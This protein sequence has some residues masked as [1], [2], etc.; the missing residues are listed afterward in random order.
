MTVT[1]YVL[2]SVKKK[3]FFLSKNPAFYN[4]IEVVP[5]TFIATARVQSWQLQEYKVQ[6]DVFAKEPAQRLIVATSINEAY[7]STN[8][9][10]F[11]LAEV[12][13]E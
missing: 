10:N 1:D 6:D 7:L 8:R 2:S 3:T 4:Y 11:S 5:K 13:V 12:W 9:A